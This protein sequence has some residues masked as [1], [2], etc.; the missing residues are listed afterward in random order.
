MSIEAG[1]QTQ[2]SN[3][4]LCTQPPKN[5]FSMYSYLRLKK[6]Q[7]FETC[8]FNIKPVWLISIKTFLLHFLETRIL[9][10][11]WLFISRNTGWQFFSSFSF[12]VCSEE[13]TA[14][15]VQTHENRISLG[16]LQK[17]ANVAP[18]WLARLPHKFEAVGSILV[19]Y[20]LGALVEYKA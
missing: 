16:L 13:W 10:K 5:S 1:R 18:R 17:F 9:V 2:H 12:Q 20:G 14:L 15:D 6:S 3:H 8:Y 7:I 11:C 19:N 4:P